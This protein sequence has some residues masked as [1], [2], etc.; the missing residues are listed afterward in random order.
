MNLSELPPTHLL[1][2]EAPHAKRTAFF[3][4]QAEQS[5]EHE[6]KQRKV[7]N[8]RADGSRFSFLEVG[9]ETGVCLR[10]PRRFELQFVR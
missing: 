1:P 7:S 6:K 3:K 9:N 10:R 2:E 4:A 5:K 8:K